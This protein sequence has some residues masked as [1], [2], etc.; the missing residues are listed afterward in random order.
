MSRS[1]Q[2]RVS[3][4]GKQFTLNPLLEGFLCL[5]CKSKLAVGDYFEGCP[6]CL[7]RDE[8]T[9]VVSVFRDPPGALC[10]TE[11]RGMSRYAPWMPYTSWVSLGEGGTSCI[12]FPALAKEVNSA[13]IFIKNEGQNPSGSH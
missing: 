12:G 3:R 8:P 4:D 6:A 7:G 2:A 11:R 13:A 5:K 10:E 1:D 9:T